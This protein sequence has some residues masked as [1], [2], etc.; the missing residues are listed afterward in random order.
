MSSL[1]PHFLTYIDYT[2]TQMLKLY[3]EYVN[4]K[5]GSRNFRSAVAEKHYEVCYLGNI[6]D[7]VTPLTSLKNISFFNSNSLALSKVGDI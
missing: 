6:V 2:L 4:G 3:I 1:T 5:A 7:R